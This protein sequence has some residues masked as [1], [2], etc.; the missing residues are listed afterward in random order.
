MTAFDH[1]NILAPIYE[2]VIK[3]KPPTDL[4]THLQLPQ[5]AQVLDV[6]GGTGRIAQAVIPYAGNITILDLSPNMLRE[7]AKK[8]GLHGVLAPSEKLPYP[9]GTF[10]AVM[11]VDALHHVVDQ[12]ASLQ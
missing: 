4:L 2:R 7:A 5:G 1:F 6:G 9:D 8:P 10:D 12:R 3:P 11:M